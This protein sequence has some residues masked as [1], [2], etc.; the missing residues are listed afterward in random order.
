MTKTLKFAIEQLYKIFSS[1][2]FPSTMEA[3]TC[4]ISTSDK[5]KLYSKSLRLLAEDDISYYSFKAMTTWGNCDNFKYYLPRIF[6]LLST[7]DFIIEIFIVLGKLDYGDWKSWERDE[8]KAINNFLY[9]WWEDLICNKLYFD[10]EAFIEIYK[11]INDIQKMLDLWIIRFD[12]H[13][14]RNLVDFILNI[15]YEFN[16]KKYKEIEK[17]AKEN[18][19][20]WLIGKVPVLEEGFFL[21][22]DKETEFAEQIS[23]ALFVIENCKV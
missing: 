21:Y 5:E 3:C 4:C 12:N 9:A 17:E 8:I 2:P 15:F 14:F 23:N 19:K 6:E 11:R 16:D 22:I 10:S 20:N 18:I 13:S 1:Y 7:T